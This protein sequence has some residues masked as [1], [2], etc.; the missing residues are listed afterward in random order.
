M[1]R[2]AQIC[3]FLIL[4]QL[5]GCAV[6]SKTE[7]LDSD[8]QRIGYKVGAEG[9]RDTV[10]AFTR[11]AEI[12]A[13]YGKQADLHAFEL[14]H[15]EGIDRYCDIPNAVKLGERGVI[16]AI[17]DQVCP[18]QQYIGFESAFYAGYRLYQLRREAD[19]MGREIDQLSQQEYRYQ[20]A[21]EDL[22]RQILSGELNE[23]QMRRARYRR[24]QLYR[25]IGSIRTSINYHQ[26]QL[27][28]AVEAA[29]TYEDLLDIEYGDYR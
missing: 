15:A 18:D 19:E 16:R 27:R 8:W 20:R 3:G 10:E 12:C 25:D 11:R 7:C 21:G 1:A 22:R 24:Q 28:Q 13:R 5:C 4:A 26:D 29:D 6:I 9:N 23:E 2:R 17:N 14:G